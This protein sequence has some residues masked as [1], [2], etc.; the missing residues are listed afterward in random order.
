MYCAFLDTTALHK[1]YQLRGANWDSIESAASLGVA[2]VAT[3]AIN[4]REL[5]RQAS[6]DADDVHRQLQDVARAFERFGSVLPVPLVPHDPLTWRRE[7]EARLAARGIELTSPANPTH[8]AILERDLDR[9]LPFKPNG[10][11]YRDTL[12][13]LSFLEWASSLRLMEEDSLFFVSANSTQFAEGGKKGSPL[14]RALE[15]E[16]TALAGVEAILLESPQALADI[17][18]PAALAMKTRVSPSEVNESRERAVQAVIELAKT[19]VDADV[20]LSTPMS[21]QAISMDA[22]MPLPPIDSGSVH[23]IEVLADRVDAQLVDTFDDTTEIWS[24]TIDAIADVAGL[25]LRADFAMSRGEVY[26]YDPDWNDHYLIAGTELYLRLRF[27]VRIE[28]LE[29]SAEAELVDVSVLEGDPE[30]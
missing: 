8:D 6:A 7:L 25:M 26:L 28:S 14:A 2:R 24:V 15:L 18:R 27:D 11:G 1:A 20:E 23:A 22:A 3:S 21:F 13:W 19:Y 17:I 5:E 9:Q 10:E 4:I 16:C 12:I 30:P 29:E